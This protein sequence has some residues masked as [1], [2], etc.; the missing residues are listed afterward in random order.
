MRERGWDAD[1][2]YSCVKREGRTRLCGGRVR[3]TRGTCGG[4]AAGRAG[5]PASVPMSG[6]REGHCFWWLRRV[7]R[8]CHKTDPAFLPPV[9]ERRVRGS[10]PHRSARP[11][12]EPGSAPLPEGHFRWR[13]FRVPWGTSSSNCPGQILSLS[14]F[15]TP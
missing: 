1:C 12:S 11:G 15:L 4:R 13:D 2:P 5:T 6:Y 7:T 8:H 14:L 9:L 3:G 10:V